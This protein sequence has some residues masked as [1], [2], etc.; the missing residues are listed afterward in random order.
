MK[1]R[2]LFVLSCAIVLA[3]AAMIFCFSTGSFSAAATGRVLGSFNHV[4]RKIAHMSE[5]ALLFLVLR[6]ALAKFM[7]G[8]KAASV[9]LLSLALCT[10]FAASDEW[11]QS[12]VPNRTPSIGDVMYDTAGALIAASL[13]CGYRFVCAKERKCVSKG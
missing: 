9:V 1:E 6:F 11:H 10:L 2:K 8:Y 4:G 5:Y 7:T 12:F 13:Y 3:V